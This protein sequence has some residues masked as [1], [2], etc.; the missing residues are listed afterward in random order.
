MTPADVSVQLGQDVR[1]VE[2]DG[3]VRVVLRKV[4]K[5]NGPAV[6]H[7]LH[8][9]DVRAGVGTHRPAGEH[10]VDRVD[11]GGALDIDRVGLIDRTGGEAPQGGGAS[12]LGVVA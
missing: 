10:L 2:L 1:A 5:R 6:Q 3:G 4:Q 12:G 8:G 7:L 11:L 9:V